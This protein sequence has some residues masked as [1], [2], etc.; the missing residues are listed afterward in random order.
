[1]QVSKISFHKGLPT[2]FCPIAPEMVWVQGK[3]IA[4]HHHQEDLPI[5]G[6]LVHRYQAWRTGHSTLRKALVF[7]RATKL[8][9]SKKKVI[10]VHKEHLPVAAPT[11]SCPQTPLSTAMRRCRCAQT[12]DRRIKEPTA[13]CTAALH[14]RLPYMP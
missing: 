6:F 8:H 10:H 1:M 2:T 13:G 9:L 14:P 5:E 4:A 3:A 11:G 7:R 12:L